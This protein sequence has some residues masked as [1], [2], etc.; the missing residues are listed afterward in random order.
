MVDA[1]SVGVEKLGALGV[2]WWVW[3]GVPHFGPEVTCDAGLVLGFEGGSID[4]VGAKVGETSTSVGEFI[5][6]NGDR[7]RGLGSGESPTSK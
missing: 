5:T 3:A 7:V 6:E 1:L 2:G 4:G